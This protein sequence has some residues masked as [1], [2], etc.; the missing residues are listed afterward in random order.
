[1]LW[2]WGWLSE[3]GAHWLL[4]LSAFVP[5]QA[6]GESVL[7]HIDFSKD[8]KRRLGGSALAHVYDQV[9]CLM[10]C[11]K[12]S[13]RK[14]KEEKSSP[15]LQDQNIFNYPSQDML[16]WTAI[17]TQAEAKKS[18]VGHTHSPPVT[19]TSYSF[20]LP[21]ARQRVPGRGRGRAQAGLQRGARP[22]RGAHHPGRA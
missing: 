18:A 13:P 10:V 14:K 15:F 8:G 9:Q 21:A 7:I 11:G 19:A 12:S 5:V 3:G 2:M 22:H 20:P 6:P 17:V 1:V 4:P 16:H